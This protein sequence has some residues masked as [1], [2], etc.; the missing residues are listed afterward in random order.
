MADKYDKVKINAIGEGAN[1][2]I[3][4]TYKEMPDGTYA[5]VTSSPDA[6]PAQSMSHG[7]SGVP[8]TSADAQ[9]GVNVTDAPSSGKKIIITDLI[10]SNRD[11][12]NTIEFTFKEETS[13]TVIAGPF[14]IKAEVTQQFTP[15]S[16]AWRLA[17]A[18]KKLQVVTSVAGNIVVDAHYYSEA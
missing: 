17:V 10:I 16:D 5:L 13:G 9:A 4:I 18:D 8:V 2:E 7:V 15:R 6:G 1:E 3:T 11:S 12:E 14:A